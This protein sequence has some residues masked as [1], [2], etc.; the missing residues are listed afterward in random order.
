MEDPT[1]PSAHTCPPDASCVQFRGRRDEHSDLHGGQRSNLPGACELLAFL[2]SEPNGVTLGVGWLQSSEGPQ[3]PSVAMCRYHK[4]TQ[5]GGTL[6]CDC[7]LPS[8]VPRKA[9]LPVHR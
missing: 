2:T 5:N 1:G 8:E 7:P 6:L 3:V 4:G 9:R